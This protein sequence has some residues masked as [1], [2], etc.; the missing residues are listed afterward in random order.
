VDEC[1]PVLLS[2]IFPQAVPAPFPGRTTLSDKFEIRVRESISSL[3][4]KALAEVLLE[5]RLPEGVHQMPVTELFVPR[6]E[7]IQPAV[8]K[9][10]EAAVK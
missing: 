1:N 3:S 5:R 6:I 2:D 8:V 4:N 10:M 7:K 9:L